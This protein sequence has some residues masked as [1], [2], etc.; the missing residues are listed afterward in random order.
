MCSHGAGEQPTN[1]AAKPIDI[2]LRISPFLM[3][4]TL[5]RIGIDSRLRWH[6]RAVTRGDHPMDLKARRKLVGELLTKVGN[7]FEA[8]I[9]EAPE[10]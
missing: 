10:H 4:S 2:N 6:F 5:C 7:G 3:P 1:A 9:A 8:I